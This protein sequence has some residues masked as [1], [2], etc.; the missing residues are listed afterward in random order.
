MISPFDITVNEIYSLLGETKRPIIEGEALVLS[1]KVFHCGIKTMAENSINIEASC[2]QTSHPTDS[3]HKINISISLVN[4][5]RNISCECTCKAG[6]G[7]RC[8]HI[9]ATLLFVNK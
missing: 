3:P 9:F 4:D 5:T 2:L 1:Q 7:N 6:A 8:K